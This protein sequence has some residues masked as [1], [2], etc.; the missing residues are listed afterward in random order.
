MDFQREH[1]KES[2]RERLLAQYLVHR[3]DQKLEQYSV[4]RLV[5]SGEKNLVLPMGLQLVVVMVHLM[6]N[7]FEMLVLQLELLLVI[8]DMF[9]GIQ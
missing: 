8:P 2:K 1:W 9:R 7:L 3:K 6:V 5:Q 4:L